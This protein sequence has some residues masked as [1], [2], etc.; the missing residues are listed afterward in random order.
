MFSRVSRSLLVSRAAARVPAAAYSGG[1]SIKDRERAFENAAV[2]KHDAELLAKLAESMPTRVNNVSIVGGGLMGAGIAQV[3]AQSGIN[4]TLIDL[5]QSVLDASRTRI[6]ESIGRVAKKKFANAGGEAEAAKWQ[7]EVVGRISGESS[8]EAGVR[9]ADLVIEAIV[10]NLQAKWALFSDIE[11]MAPKS[12]VFASNTSSLRIADIASALGDPSRV[13]GLH[14]FNPVPVMKLVEVVSAERTSAK[15][16]KSLTAFGEKI[17]KQVVQCRDTPGFIV[18]RLLVPFMA[19]AMRL[20]ERGD[21]SLEDI[22][23]AMKLGAAHPMGPLT[24]SDYV[25]LDTCKFIMDGWYEQYGEPLFKTPAV[26]SAL[27][28]AGY[29]GNKSA[30]GGFYVNGKPNPE[31]AKILASVGKH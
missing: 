25:G 31:L 22:D 24:L 14:F 11:K 6:G 21:A 2:R 7:A 13:G 9:N 20:L 23:V 16:T 19:E 30:K 28:E 12:A 29:L 26:L 17:G 4:V 3:A 1:D 8:L 15:T 10:E 27:V 18:N 5:N